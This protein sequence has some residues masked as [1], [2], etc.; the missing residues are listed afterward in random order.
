MIKFAADEN[1][2]NNIIRG[3]LRQRP[4]IDIIRI[5]DAGLSGV[6]DQTVLEWA[7]KENRILLTHDV[8]TITKYAYERIA[9]SQSVPGVFEINPKIKTGTPAPSNTEPE[10]PE[11]FCRLIILPTF[12]F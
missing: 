6:D 3:L 4:D 5:Q 10:A 1:L 11:E 7:S 9:N 8:S 2:N 12:P